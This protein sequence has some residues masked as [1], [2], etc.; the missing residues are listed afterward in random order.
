MGLAPNRSA[1]FAGASIGCEVPDPIL[2]QPLR[3]VHNFELFLMVSPRA[4]RGPVAG[5]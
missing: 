5:R 3:V 4:E 1:I 2:S